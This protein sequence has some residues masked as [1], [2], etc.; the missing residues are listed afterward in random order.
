MFTTFRHD[1]KPKARKLRK[2][3]TQPEKKLWFEFL[4]SNSS[5]KFLRQKPIGNY[6]V[7]FY[8]AAKKLVIEVDG[9]SHFI[10]EAAINKDLQRK[11]F[12]K[13]AH[14]IKILRFSNLEV[15]Q[16]FEGVC[17]EIERNLN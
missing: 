15:M 4:R 8:C 6:I 12:L 16:N 2:D 1:L 11:I 3:M 9:D 10:S 5:Q 7:D 17:L 13:E 14:Q